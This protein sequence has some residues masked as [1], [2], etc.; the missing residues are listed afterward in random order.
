MPPLPGL[1]ITIPCAV[2]NALC[3][4]NWFLCGTASVLCTQVKAGLLMSKGEHW[5]KKGCMY[6]LAES[7]PLNLKWSWQKEEWVVSRTSCYLTLKWNL[8]S[9]RH[10]LFHCDVLEFKRFACM[11]VSS[12][13]IKWWTSERPESRENSSPWASVCLLSFIWRNEWLRRGHLL[14]W[15]WKDS[16]CCKDIG[17]EK[18]A[19]KDKAGNILCFLLTINPVKRPKL[20]KNWSYTLVGYRLCKQVWCTVAY[21]SVAQ[22]QC[23]CFV[24]NSDWETGRVTNVVKWRR[25]W[26]HWSWIQ[27]PQVHDGCI[28]SL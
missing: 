18:N 6:S 20:T 19:L 14:F 2:Q 27:E 16:K 15:K 23:C 7:I 28:S 11:N 9:R 17:G 25:E 4:D 26:K 12:I 1:K 24:E 13:L 3:C 8:Q 22:H 21:F 5:E 10:F